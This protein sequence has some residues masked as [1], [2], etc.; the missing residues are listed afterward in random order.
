PFHAHALL[1]S[2]GSIN[3]LVFFVGVVLGY[4]GIEIAGIHA[5]EPRNPRRDFPKA[6]AMATGLIVGVSVLTTLAIAFVVPQAKLSLVS[7]VLQAFDYFFKT[8]G[9][10]S[11]ATKLMAALTGLGTLA[12]VSTWLLGPSK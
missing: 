12:L 8:I 11:W 5:K 7:G 9:I 6:L 2:L 10:G 3:N 1:P 4:A